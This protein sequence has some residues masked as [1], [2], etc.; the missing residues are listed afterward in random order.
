[1]IT[2][3]GIHTSLLGIFLITIF[4][5][6]LDALKLVFE[7][8]SAFGTVG[9]SMGVTSSLSVA[10]KLLLTII[11]YIGRIGPFTVLTLFRFS[12]VERVRYAEG[13]IAIG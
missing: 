11:M 4:D 7:V 8:F 13:D 12:E 5:K 3:V 10:S 1:I 2:L 6:D 9:L